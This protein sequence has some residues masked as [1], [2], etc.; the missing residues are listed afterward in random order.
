LAYPTV[1]VASND[2]GDVSVFMLSPKASLSRR[3]EPLAA[4]GD[5]AV[6]RATGILA[7]LAIGAIHFL[8][9]AATFKTA[10][11]LGVAFVSLIMASIVAAARLVVGA[12]TRALLGAA[13]VGLAAIAGYIFTRM[14][15][16][17]LDNQDVGNWSEMLGLAALFVEGALVVFSGYGIA[18]VRSR[19]GYGVRSHALQP[20]LAER[21]DST[22]A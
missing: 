2:V 9:L 11:L 20:Q 22:A 8:Q 15:S 17:P 16:S 3:T 4:V 12:D 19:A 5:D 10:P 18:L 1:T 6:L 21:G 14:I 13:L 7:L